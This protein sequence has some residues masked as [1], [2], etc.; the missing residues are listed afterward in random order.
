MLSF[1]LQ[2]IFKVRGIDKPY[3]FLVKSGMT[4]HAA[5]TILN[6]STRTFRLDHIEHLCKVLFCEPN[7]LLHW[8]PESGEQFSENFPLKKLSK[9]ENAENWKQTLATMPLSELKEITKK[10]TE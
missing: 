10:I 7:D 4:P 9:I 6:S 1:N 2:P 3:S 8:K 5:N